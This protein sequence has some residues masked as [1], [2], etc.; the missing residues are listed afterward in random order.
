MFFFY[1]YSFLASLN[2]CFLHSEDDTIQ[3]LKD[4]IHSTPNESLFYNSFL[5]LY[6]SENSNRDKK[7][8][9]NL[10]RYSQVLSS[11]VSNFESFNFYL[12][13]L[14]GM[15]NLDPIKF[16]A[17]F[18]ITKDD[19]P[20]C[21]IY[22]LNDP[23]QIFQDIESKLKILDDRSFINKLKG[24][25]ALT[26]VTT[27]FRLE[28]YQKGCVNKINIK[29]VEYCFPDSKMIFYKFGNSELRY[30]VNN[31]GSSNFPGYT[32]W[33]NSK[34][35]FAISNLN[36]GQY[37]QN[38][39]TTTNDQN[40][41]NFY[42]NI[43]LLYK[44]ASNKIYLDYIIKNIDEVVFLDDI[45]LNLDSLKI[46]KVYGLFFD[47]K[48]V[49]IL[50]K[51]G[52]IWFFAYPLKND[53]VDVFD[54]IQNKLLDVSQNDF[55]SSMK[56]ADASSWALSLYKFKKD[57]NGNFIGGN[58]DVVF[59]RIKTPLR[60]PEVTSKL[61]LDNFGSRGY[62]L[63]K[64]DK[65][66]DSHF[67]IFIDWSEHFK[68]NHKQIVEFLINNFPNNKTTVF[69]KTPEGQQQ[70]SLD[71]LIINKKI[72]TYLEPHQN[73]SFNNLK[74]LLIKKAD[75]NKENAQIVFLTRNPKTTFGDFNFRNDEELYE[76]KK[77]IYDMDLTLIQIE[78]PPVDFFLKLFDFEEYS[79][80]S[81]GYHRLDYEN[82]SKLKFPIFGD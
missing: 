82:T 80:P 45:K 60:L 39:I 2:I 76:F 78:G 69:V 47:Y 23:L 67:K 7:F 56:N 30:S 53:P 81:V 27:V 51:Q 36:T 49:L 70:I 5:N 9:S 38:L 20:W 52:N 50:T 41:K 24:A 73:S 40:L 59:K 14:D 12:K 19:I 63:S 58:K 18:L 6:K 43:F 48:V 26:W 57:S 15:L 3:F 29:G 21:F 34:R 74:S 31:F 10:I 61:I 8:F 33:Y 22:P 75:S 4:K 62:Y 79:K 64:N 72:V 11:E 55:K 28:K 32:D 46:P 71:D 42:K 54:L 44:S 1:L 77:D 35:E 65:S 66:L 13:D 37:V 17:K 25:D 68:N 16:K